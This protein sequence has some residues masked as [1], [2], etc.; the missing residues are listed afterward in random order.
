M[1]K[2]D[3][4]LT[5]FASQILGYEVS[6]GSDDSAAFRVC[7]RLRLPLAKVLGTG[8]FA[9]LLSRALTLAGA[10]IS[11]LQGLQ[12]QAD[13]SLGG[14]ENLKVKPDQ[15]AVQEG[16]LVL[17]SKLIALLVTFIGQPLT[18]Q[19]LQGVWTGLDGPAFPRQK[20]S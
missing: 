4:V 16:E 17:F 1:L 11:W 2:Q 5:E 14:L 3:P 9:S 19:L 15:D 6:A 7:E 10:E 12:V 18:L 13:G 20:T 8:G